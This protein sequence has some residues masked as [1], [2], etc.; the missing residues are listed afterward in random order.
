MQVLVSKSNMV[1]SKP[2]S[3]KNIDHTR[4]NHQLTLWGPVSVQELPEV[5]YIAE[6]NGDIDD[7]EEPVPQ[8]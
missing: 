2:N 4:L 3:I 1:S 5:I 6:L 8:L 7:G